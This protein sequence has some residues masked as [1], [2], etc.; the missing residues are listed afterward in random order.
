MSQQQV[1]KPDAPASQPLTSVSTEKRRFPRRRP[2][3]ILQ[4]VDDQGDVIFRFKLDLPAEAESQPQTLEDF[5]RDSILDL[6]KIVRFYFQGKPLMVDAF[7]FLNEPH[8]PIKLVK[9]SDAP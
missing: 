6:L 2:Q 8:L 5:Y 7:A 1:K 9:K 3:P 4:E